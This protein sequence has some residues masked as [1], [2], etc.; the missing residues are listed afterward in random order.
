MN[1]A[2]FPILCTCLSALLVIAGCADNE[3]LEYRYTAEKMFH[4]ANRMARD[5]GIKSELNAP[6]A[7]ARI[8][9]AYGST[10]TYC[11]DAL[12]HVDS[13]A[14]PDEYLELSS[15]AYHSTIRLSQFLYSEKGFDSC[16]A[17]YG[18][19]RDLTGLTPYQTMFASLN[20]GQ[21]MQAK[22]RWEEAV[23]IYTDAYNGY[24]PP[25]APNGDVEFKLFNLPMHIFQIYN[26]VGDTTEAYTTYLQAEAYYRDLINDFP[27]SDVAVAARSSLASLYDQAGRHDDAI[28]QL[29]ALTDSAG[30]VSVSAQLQVADIRTRRLQQFREA[31]GIY[32]R[33]WSEVSGRDT[34]YRPVILYQRALTLLELKRY[35][36]A[37]EVL[38]QLSDLY[39]RYYN[40]M[41]TAQLVKARSFELE[42]NWQRAETEF[43]YLMENFEGSDEAMSTYLHLEQHYAKQRLSAEANR[44]YERGIENYDKLTAQPG[45]VAARALMY[46]AEM[47]RQRKMWSEAAAALEQLYGRFPDTR[48]GRSALIT[49]SEIYRQRLRKPDVADSLIEAYKRTMVDPVDRET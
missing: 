44:W 39:P 11:Y 8:R 27:S 6:D 48:V 22:G 24:Y 3:A 35:G 40:S 25:I 49:A 18:R 4:N 43:R 36:E 14:N 38:I 7:E 41:P 2:Y 9:D 20:L 1:R 37:R 21:V 23:T 26:R 45:S 32:D 16:I 12:T 19:L 13:A 29:N 47:Y 34:T 10:L 28:A 15:L 5:A 33:L 31:L 46:K 30:V 17:L 42:G